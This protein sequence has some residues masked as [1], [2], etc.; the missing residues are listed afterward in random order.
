M[1]RFRRGFFCKCVDRNAES[2]GDLLRGLPCRIM[3]ASF[4][5]GNLNAVQTDG[6]REALLSEAA[7]F[8]Q[9]FQFLAESVHNDSKINPR[10]ALA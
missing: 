7:F 4:Q 3:L 8:S 5:L 2:L 1:F 9:G 6:V 10:L